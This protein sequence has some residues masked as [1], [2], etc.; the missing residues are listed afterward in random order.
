[1]ARTNGAAAPAHER[2][3]RPA[4]RS[5]RIERGAGARLRTARLSEKERSV[6]REL[7]RGH[8]TE[9][10]AEVLIV[11]PHTVRTHIKNGMRKLEARTRAHAVAIALSEGAIEFEPLPANS[12]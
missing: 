5:V 12:G 11:S 8:S 9:Q 3:P 6:L 4:L 2:P 7:A 1:M 10:I